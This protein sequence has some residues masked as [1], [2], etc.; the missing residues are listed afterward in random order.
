MNTIEVH[1]ILLSSKLF[2]C[3]PSSSAILKAFADVNEL[4]LLHGCQ[5]I[6][7]LGVGGGLS[8]YRITLPSKK[9]GKKLEERGEKGVCTRPEGRR[10]EIEVIHFY[11]MNYVGHICIFLKK[12]SFHVEQLWTFFYSFIFSLNQRNVF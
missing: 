9:K 2:V 10:L 1:R 5:A 8:V 3:H 7:L 11:N 6:V 12:C 4:L